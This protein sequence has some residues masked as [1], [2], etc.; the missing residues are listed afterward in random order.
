MEIYTLSKIRPYISFSFCKLLRL[1]S[2]FFLCKFPRVVKNLNYLYDTSS[3][4]CG[5]RETNKII[6]YTYCD[7]LT[8]GSTF[9][10]LEK[11]VENMDRQGLYSS[12]GY[13]RE[14][15]TNKEEHVDSYKIRM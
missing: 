1:K 10:E 8:G 5:K 13:C 6:K 3:K 15:L 4:I 9:E 12:I 2:F 7:F 11:T 14:F